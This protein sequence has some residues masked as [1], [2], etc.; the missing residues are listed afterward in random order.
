V[1]G[2][3]AAAAP[4]ETKTLDVSNHVPLQIGFGQTDYF[5]G[6]IR[7]VRLY[8]RALSE[9]DVAS[10]FQEREVSDP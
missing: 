8:N 3:L 10:L 4:C 5:S 1:N 9:A 6:K 2:Q 7:A